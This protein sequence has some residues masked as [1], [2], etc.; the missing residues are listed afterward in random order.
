MMMTIANGVLKKRERLKRE[1]PMITVVCTPLMAR[2]HQNIQ[3]A[4]E[5][6]FCDAKS[7]LDRF[8]SS[9]F[10]FSTSSAA[11]GLPLGVI[12]ITSDEQEDTVRQRLQLLTEVVPDGA[13]YGRG[14]EQGPAI[15]MTDDSSAERNALQSVWPKTKRLLCVFH[16]LQQNWTWLHDGTNKIDNY[17][18]MTLI[19]QAKSL[20]FAE[21]EEKLVRLYSGLINSDILK[22]YPK[23]LAYVATHW[24]RGKEWAV[25]YRQHILVRGN[26]TNN[27]A[28]AGFRI[29]KDL[30]FN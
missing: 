24:R 30:I 3:Q 12:I 6:V 17:D 18:R 5:M 27:Y 25:C 26:H 9:L 23:Y 8:N 15:V 22:K 16:F 21:S 19:C 13:F 4:G 28:E 1:Q 11:G 2:V 29:L 7:S 20:V 10:L 14:G